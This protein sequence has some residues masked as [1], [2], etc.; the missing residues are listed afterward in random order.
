MI[1][2]TIGRPAQLT[3]A[4]ESLAGGRPRPDEVLIV[5]QSRGADTA[6]LARDHGCRRIA[7]DGRGIGLALN[8]GL[9]AASHDL[10][11]ITNDD[12]TV[13]EDWIAV[14]TR[15]LAG[16]PRPFVTGAV[17]PAGGPAAVPSLKQ[18]PQP[19][20][21]EGTVV[22]DALYGANMAVSRSELL[23]AGGF[24]ERI[25]PTA[26]DNDLCYRWLRDGR[27]LRYQPAMRVWHHDWR[28]GDELRR[29]Y[30]SYGAGQGM[31]YA[32]HLIARDRT[33]LRFLWRDLR[34][35]V[36]SVVGALLRGERPP[37]WSEGTLLGL[38]AGLARG[39][40]TFA[41]TSS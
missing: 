9:R 19:R 11:L 21:Y 33:V 31:F 22:D 34:A 39:L 14:A 26:E 23:A 4:L 24:D 6:R 32:K 10:V 29:L 12:C 2:P 30:R 38:P 1:I 18:D 37:A 7:S 16:G 40:R 28:D 17:L 3:A 13:A 15:E 25:T 35:S 36:P 20:D 5:A 27:S 41:R 8:A